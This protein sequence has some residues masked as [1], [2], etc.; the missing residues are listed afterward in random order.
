[1]LDCNITDA[2]YTHILKEE[3]GICS[4]TDTLISMVLSELRYNLGCNGV[5][6]CYTPETCIG[7]TTVSCNIVLSQQVGSASN[8]NIVLTQTNDIP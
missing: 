3:Y 4:N 1:M 6:L 2:L 8:C 5:V 7:S